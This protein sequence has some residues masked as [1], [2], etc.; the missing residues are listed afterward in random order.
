[1]LTA[2]EIENCCIKFRRWE[3][4]LDL[5]LTQKFTI[6]YLNCEI[7]YKN[8]KQKRKLCQD[9]LTNNKTFLRTK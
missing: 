7:K 9:V 6:N 1:M 8:K 3:S 2:L 5:E 4:L